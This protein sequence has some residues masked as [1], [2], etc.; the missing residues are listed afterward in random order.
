[1]QPCEVFSTQRRFP[2]LRELLF[3]SS[4]D[5]TRLMLAYT[6][7]AYMWLMER[8]GLARITLDSDRPP[9]GDDVWRDRVEFATGAVSIYVHQPRL[10]KAEVG[11]RVVYAMTEAKEA[12]RTQVVSSQDTVIVFTDR[13]ALVDR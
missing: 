2:H 1:M 11:Y 5:V 4:D 12:A 9:Q 8:S 6:C 10:A 3:E 7:S 13:C